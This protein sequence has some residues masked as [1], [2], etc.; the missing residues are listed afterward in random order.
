MTTWKSVR[1][2]VLS[3][4]HFDKME[5]ELD[6]AKKL[7]MLRIEQGLTQRQL[8]DRAGIKQPQL[9]RLESAKQL[10]RLDTL[11]QI[12]NAVGY[13]VEIKFVPKTTMKEDKRLALEAAGWQVGTVTEFLD[14]SVE[15]AVNIENKLND[16]EVWEKYKE[17]EHE[18]KEVYIKLAAEPKVKQHYL[19]KYKSDW[20][21]EMDIYG[22]DLLTDIDKKWFESLNPTDDKPLV[23]HVGTNE[24]IE[25]TDSKTFLEAYTWTPI[26]VEEREVLKKLVG[27]EYGH[28]FYPYKDEEDEEIDEEW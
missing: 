25:Y 4:E 11:Q 17:S 16:S 18:R 27:T 3:K 2:D 12:A 7:F 8:A 5:P 13:C 14:L 28:F 20:A 22:L 6:I 24:D 21:D 19:V 10:A 26:T 1:D 15:E 23:H 9:A